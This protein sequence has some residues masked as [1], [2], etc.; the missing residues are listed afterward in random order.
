MVQKENGLSV[1]FGNQ[2]YLIEMIT[3]SKIV[4]R[5]K[6]LDDALDDYTWQS[7][8]ELA[9]LDAAPRLT[10]SFYQYLMDYTDEL[11][12]SSLTRRAFAIDTLDGRH[13]GNCGYYGIDEARGDTELGI[14]MGDRDYWDQ[15][16]GADAVNT[17]VDYIFRATRLNRIHL[18]TLDWNTRAHRCFQKCGFAP[19]G[20]LNRDG[21]NFLLMETFR[22]QRQ[23]PQQEG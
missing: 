12:Y 8:A 9:R 20:R 5:E 14:I 3:G 11:R 4:L 19:C 7:D 21:Y 16:Y 17:L 18:K 2:A 10:I 6:K 15:G 23:L 1:P 13:I 22:H